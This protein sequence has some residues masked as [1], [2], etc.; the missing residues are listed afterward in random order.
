MFLKSIL[1]FIDFIEFD[2]YH[3]MYSLCIKRVLNVENPQ[4]II[5]KSAKMQQTTLLIILSLDGVTVV[6]IYIHY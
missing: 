4:I 2:N 3:C 6:F 1:D 5:Q